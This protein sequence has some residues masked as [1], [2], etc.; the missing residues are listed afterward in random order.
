MPRGFKVLAGPIYKL[1][2]AVAPPDPEVEVCVVSFDQKRGGEP[3]VMKEVQRGSLLNFTSEKDV[4]V[5][6]PDHSAV[7]NWGKLE[8]RSNALV[9]DVQGGRKL[10]SGKAPLI[11]PVEMLDPRC[12]W[13][14]DGA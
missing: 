3:A 4:W 14:C 8:I 7:S 1:N 13:S 12:R 2:L 5:L 6:M 10:S 9:V 11:E